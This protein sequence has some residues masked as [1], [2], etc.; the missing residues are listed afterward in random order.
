MG[1]EYQYA[2]L[3]NARSPGLP[4]E[5]CSARLHRLAHAESR[6]MFLE[7][8]HVISTPGR[9]AKALLSRCQY[10]DGQH[11]DRLRHRLTELRV[12]RRRAFEEPDPDLDVLF[13]E[14]MHSR[15][16]AELLAALTLVIKPAM[17]EAYRRYERE[18]NGLADY[19]S[20]RALREIVAEEEEG[21][22]LLRPA[23]ADAV[24]SSV[25]SRA[26]A[27]EWSAHLRQLLEAAGG[28]D[29]SGGKRPEAL[30]T[31]RGGSPYRIPRQQAWD[32]TF[33]KVWDIEH[34][35]EEEMPPRLAQM[36]CTRLG[37]L[38]IAEALSFVLCETAGQPWQ[39]YVDVS[40]HMWDEMRHSL[41]GE[42][43]GE[44]LLGDRAALPLREWETEYLYQ[45]EPLP[46]YAML[47][48]VES[49]LMKY[50]PGKRFE[51]EFCRDRARH[52]LMTTLQDF[53]WADEVLHV[54]IARRRLKAW[55]PGSQ[56]E[57][58]ALAAGGIE[59]R[60]RAREKHPPSPLPDISTALAGRKPAGREHEEPSRAEAED[61]AVK[62]D[63]PGP[64]PASGPQS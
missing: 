18:T 55:F 7:A 32:D 8:A 15:G 42:A 11:A 27:E 39:F 19:G 56:K 33:P 10:E 16:T 40:R 5:V 51:Y 45:L 59:A 23:Y 14:A 60:T 29:G 22:A 21:L 4:V 2:G 47:C 6:L 34:V 58:A 61:T 37:E 64:D 50:P 17:I 31:S 44:D 13:D 20:L 1:S 57:L 38:T 3:R 30:R 52:P 35:G 49:G 24:G 9:D 63:R 28:I 48:D 53:D 12:S 25:R 46:L 54:H 62:P 43:A 36:I 41:F 26:L